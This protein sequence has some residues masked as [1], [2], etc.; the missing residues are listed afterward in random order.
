M[1]R[2]RGRDGDPTLG[3][4]VNLRLTPLRVTDT[5]TVREQKNLP[6]LSPHY[7]GGGYA[8]LTLRH[9]DMR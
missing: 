2:W 9:I 3:E 7:N 8:P 1:Y 6:L 4:G 5:V